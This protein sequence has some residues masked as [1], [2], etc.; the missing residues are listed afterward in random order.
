MS[1]QRL[2]CGIA[3][4]VGVGQIEQRHRGRQ[5]EQVHGGLVQPRLDGVAVFYQ[6]VGGPV[7][8]HRPHGFVFHAQQFAQTAV[9]A[10]PAVGLAL[11]G[12]MRHAADDQAGRRR[13]QRAVDA[14]FL[15]QRH[16]P[17]LLQGPQPR[18]LD[19]HAARPRQCHGVRMDRHAVR[20]RIGRHADPPRQ[21]QGCDALRFGLDRLGELGDQRLLA[22][23]QV[24]DPGA[25]PKPGRGLDLEVAAEVQQRAL[26]DLVAA[27]FAAD[28]SAGAVAG[29]VR[30]AARLGAAD[31]HGHDRR[32]PPPGAC[33][34]PN[35]RLWHY[36]RLPRPA[37]TMNQ[38]LTHE[39]PR[40]IS[41]KLPVQASK[42]LK[43]VN[44]G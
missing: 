44:L 43:L 40:K 12:R 34:Y 11:A 4:E 16:Q 28:Q 26:P 19:A 23:E 13:P 27:A 1:R 41:E 33:Q 3:L 10:Q 30:G 42:R 18:L 38:E 22:V 6:G 29:A 9:A 8:L 25:Q 21:Q 7:Q 5:A 17:D 15:Q 32:P 35:E 14:Q 37:K 31:K 24:L 20:R 2:F 39:N 36:I